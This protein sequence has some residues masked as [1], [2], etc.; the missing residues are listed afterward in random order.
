MM[1]SPR[2]HRRA[3]ARGIPL[4]QTAGRRV[5]LTTLLEPMSAEPLSPA[6]RFRKTFGPGMLLAAAAIGVSHLVQSTRAGAD[7]G[8]SLVWIVLFA[9]ALKYPFFE[10]GP[11]YAAGTGESLVEGYLRQGRW[12]LW[13]FLTLTVVTAVA[14]ASAVGLFT[15]FLFAHVLGLTHIVPQVGVAVLLA[16]GLLLWFGRFAALDL[17]IKV[18]VVVLA[19]CTLLAAA[20]TLPHAP[21]ATWTPWPAGGSAVPFAFILALAGLIVAAILVFHLFAGNL[22]RMVDLATILGFLTAPVLGYL[23][24]R[25]VTAPHVPEAYRPGPVLRTF[26]YLGLALLAGTAV[27]F[28]V[29][30]LMF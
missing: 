23:N 22:H 6:A 11:R 24:L 2:A 9:L 15:A 1:R 29:R 13:V 5:L 25:A 26:S 19:V 17:T 18:V 7:A 12:A 10:F 20:F 30:R 21:A 27:V 4:S 16:S 3:P 8:F 14:V 28:I